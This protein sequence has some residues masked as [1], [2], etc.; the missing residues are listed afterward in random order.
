MTAVASG[1]IEF[2][3]QAC[4]LRDGS[5][6][7]VG[8]RCLAAFEGAV[9]RRA[10]DAEEVCELGGAVVASLEERDQVGLLSGVELGL[11]AAEPALSLDPW[12][13]WLTALSLDGS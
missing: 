9:D 4:G 10:A 8:P 6:S 13:G 11:L 12:T 5:R 3:P 1:C 7:G 2:V